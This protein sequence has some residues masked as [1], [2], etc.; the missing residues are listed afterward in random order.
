MKSLIR[1]ILIESIDDKIV[2]LS[3]NS[4]IQS[5]QTGIIPGGVYFND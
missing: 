1:K 4:E 3:T 2:D 5:I